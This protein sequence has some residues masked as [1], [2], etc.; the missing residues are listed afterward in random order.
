MQ[1][2]L[3]RQPQVLKIT[4]LSRSSLYLAINGGTF[5]KPIKISERGV[6]F[7]ESEV[8]EWVQSRIEKSRKEVA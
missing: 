4:G 6:A 5:P 7:V 8:D 1:N 2:N 3:L